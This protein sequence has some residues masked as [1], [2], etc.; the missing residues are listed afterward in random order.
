MFSKASTMKQLLL[1]LFCLLTGMAH[2]SGKED[3]ILS[4]EAG[5]T[6]DFED[7]RHTAEIDGCQMTT[8]RWRD[9]PEHG[10]VLWSSFQFD[11]VDGILSANAGTQEPRYHYAIMEKGVTERGL[12]V[13][14]FKMREGTFARFERSALRVASADTR[15]SPRGDGTTHYYQ[16]S[17]DFFIGMQGAGVAEKAKAF[18][19]GYERYVR[20][21]CTFSS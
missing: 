17:D 18:T 19:E 11:M 4:I 20:E 14:Q 16:E 21:Y 5:G 8:Y 3:L 2:A 15:P 9:M 12:V 1:S 6:N 13:I 7:E 10:W